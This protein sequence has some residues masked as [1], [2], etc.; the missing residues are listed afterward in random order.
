[1]LRALA[2]RR[3]PNL[4][5]GVRD[6][7]KPAGQI[8]RGSSSGAVAAG[9]GTHRLDLAAP[10]RIRSNCLQPLGCAQPAPPP[11]P[12]GHAIGIGSI[13]VARVLIVG[14]SDR[15][16]LLASELCE[17][18]HPTRIVTTEASRRAEIE[19]VGA[20]CRVGDPS[21]LGTI[22]SALDSVTVACW[23]L[24]DE[25]H[26]DLHQGRLQ[27]FLGKAIDSTMRGFL[28]EA[29]G[30]APQTVLQRGVEVAQEIAA[31]NQIPLRV[32]RADPRH[33]HEWVSAALQAIDELISPA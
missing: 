11:R 26:L 10:S 32:L 22:T 2:L 13:L 16:L 23:L 12:T 15:A 8:V 4:S 14:D 29:H 30:S 1:M 9:H 24:A 25:P 27:A 5:G 31:S 20:E 28:Y 6:G 17:R 18:E 33:T 19:R 3:Y 7:L 21:R